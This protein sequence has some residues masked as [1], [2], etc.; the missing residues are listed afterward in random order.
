[1][2]KPLFVWAILKIYGLTKTWGLSKNETLALP[3]AVLTAK[4]RS[5]IIK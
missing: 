4:R 2:I 1:L 5:R 3:F